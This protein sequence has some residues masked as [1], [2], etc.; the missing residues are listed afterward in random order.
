MTEHNYDYFGVRKSV[1]EHLADATAAAGDAVPPPDPKTLTFEPVEVSPGRWQLPNET[2]PNRFFRTHDEARRAG[3]T[4]EAHAQREYANY[5]NALPI[6]TKTVGQEAN[7]TYEAGR[8]TAM[9]EGITPE[10]WAV[11]AE[12]RAAYLPETKTGA[13]LWQEHKRNRH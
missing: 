3:F 2:N 10:A 7:E 8:A 11:S 5:V 13:E 12:I 4:A 1:A 9:S 6:E